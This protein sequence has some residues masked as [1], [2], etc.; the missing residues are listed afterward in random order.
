MSLESVEIPPGL[1][2][3]VMVS[4]FGSIAVLIVVLLFLAFGPSDFTTFQNIVI[5]LVA[6]LVLGA[7]LTAVWVPWSE[8]FST[9]K[10]AWSKRMERVEIERRGKRS[11]AHSLGAIIYMIV[12]LLYLAFFAPS[13]FTLF[14]NIA[15]VLVAALVLAA[16]ESVIWIPRGFQWVSEELD[17]ETLEEE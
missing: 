1:K 9:Q 11:V 6:L 13:D 5:V 17:K 4:V 14:Q 12:V 3:R 2:M 8:H 7:V 10:D 16:I 15:L